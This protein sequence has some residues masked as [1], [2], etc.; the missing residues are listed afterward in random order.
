MMNVNPERALQ[1]LVAAMLSLAAFLASAAT[2][3]AQGIANSFTELRLLVRPGDKISVIGTD[4]VEVTGR[5]TQLT[6]AAVTLTLEGRRRDFEEADVTTIRQRRPDSL[7]NGAL[8]GMAV[9]G[10]LMLVGVAAS[11]VHDDEEAGWWVLGTLVYAG[12]GA[13]IGAGID[14]LITKPQVIYERPARLGARL[15]VA[16]I[17]MP[18]R[19]GVRASLSF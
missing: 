8:I 7:Q 12:V 3:D 15:R 4:G 9:G 11:G 5:L 16:P 14:A 1:G 17:L 19:Q 10:G 2:V 13:G 18:R 6:A